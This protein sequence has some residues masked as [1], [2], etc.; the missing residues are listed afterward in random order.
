MSVYV[1]GVPGIV[2]ALATKRKTIEQSVA[3]G[4]TMGAML[5]Q[6]TARKKIMNGP[7][8]GVSYKRGKK[9]HRAS[10]P[11]EAP[12]NDTG[13]LQRTINIVAAKPSDRSTAQVTCMSLYANYL[14]NGTLDGKL[15]ARPF[16]TPSAEE[17]APKIVTM[18]REE[19]EKA[20]AS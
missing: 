8:S 2:A 17:C 18:L 5:I 3:R 4:V 13:N 20:I 15:E 10:A 11:G 14:E 9:S 16:M 6:K 12:A 7:K 1:V 19:V